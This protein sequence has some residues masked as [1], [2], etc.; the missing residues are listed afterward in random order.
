MGRWA[1]ILAFA[2]LC[3]TGSARG[4]EGE[5]KNDVHVTHGLGTETCPGAE[6]VHASLRAHDVRNARGS[7]RFARFG[8]F[9]FSAEVFAYGQTKFLTDADCAK[10]LQQATLALALIVPVSEAPRASAPLDTPLPRRRADPSDAPDA[11]VEIAEPASVAPSR[12]PPVGAIHVGGRVSGGLSRHPL[13]GIAFGGWLRVWRPLSIGATASFFASDGFDYRAG[14]VE[15][16]I[17]GVTVEACA[18]VWQRA[19]FRMAV[20]AGTS[21]MDFQT[22]GAFFADNRLGR[23]VRVAP[24][25]GWLVAFEPIAGLGPGVRAALDVPLTRKS[26][27]TLQGTRAWLMPPLSASITAQINYLFR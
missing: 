23:F 6:A 4:D 9:A 7:V 5:A 24:E 10:L 25:L 13:V 18:D 26:Y 2:S 16:D 17:W 19:R 27:D 1:P 14:R 20:C 21:I 12:T 3:V 15:N 22:R 8:E 11:P